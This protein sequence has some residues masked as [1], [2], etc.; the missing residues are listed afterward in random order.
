MAASASLPNR[1]SWL[2]TGQMEISNSWAVSDNQ[3]KIRGYRIELGEIEAVLTKHPTVK[4]CVVVV[5]EH[6]SRT[7][8]NVSGLCGAQGT[9]DALSR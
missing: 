7:G 4:D 6:E 1:R 5:C 2:V 9:F 3:V 8:K